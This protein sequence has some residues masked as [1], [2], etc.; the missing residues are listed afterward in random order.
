MADTVMTLRSFSTVWARLRY[1]RLKP[2]DSCSVDGRAAER[3]RLA[4]WSAIA[5]LGSRL[6]GMLLMMLTVYWASPYLGAERFGVWATFASLTAMLS[7]LDLGVGNALINRVARAVA[8]EDPIALRRVV[9][10]GIGWLALIGVVVAIAFALVSAVVPWAQFFRL[11]SAEIG[12]ETRQAA[13]VFSGLFGAQLL[14]SGPMKILAG[15]QRSYEGH[16]I[17]MACALLAC[18]TLWWATRHG[19]GIVGLLVAG[20]GIQSLAGL[21]VIPLL[22]RRGQLLFSQL[23]LGM[24]QERGTLLRTGS[25]FFLLQIGTMIGWGGDSL[26]I[27]SFGGAS[28][29][30]AFAVAQRLFQFASQPI[31]VMNAPLWAAYADACVHTDRSFL[32]RTLKRSLTISVGGATGLVT[33]LLLLAPW[34]LPHWT[35]GTIDVP[36]TLLLLMGV[37]TVIEVGGSAFAMYLNGAGIV[38]EQVVVVFVFCIVA[39]PLKIISAVHI[40]AAGLVA[41]TIVAYILT[42]VGLYTTLFRR[43][44][45]APLGKDTTT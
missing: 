7:F 16:L 4:A 8:A 19:A 5:N 14:A 9:T 6:A 21:A 37:W 11:S 13:L 27:A 17:S 2:F 24:R 43:R 45:L 31:A 23:A 1:L 40:G 3:Y 28:Q 15:Q 42:N 36:R 34:L 20:Q 32:Q 44:V 39:L 12:R 35:Q 25:L 18:A 29:V 22:R 33:V 30:A 26:L 41:A 10:G 38:R